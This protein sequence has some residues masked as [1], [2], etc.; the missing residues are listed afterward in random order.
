MSDRQAFFFDAYHLDV[1]VVWH[2]YHIASVRVARGAWRV[3]NL[4]YFGR[5]PKHL[6]SITAQRLDRLG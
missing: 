4:E 2:G 6:T 3:P 1:K 5:P